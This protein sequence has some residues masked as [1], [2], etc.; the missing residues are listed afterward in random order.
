[1]LRLCGPANEYKHNMSDETMSA[2]A[3]LA[4]ATDHDAGVDIDSQPT[5]QTQNKNE[6]ASVEQDSSNERSASKEVDGGEQ[7]DVGTS[8]SS[9]TDSKAK[10]KEEKPKDQKSKFTQDQNR[11]TKTWE[12]INAEKEAIRADR[13]AVKR[14]REEWSKQREQST[15]ADTNSFRDEKG[16]TAEDY[17]AAAK[18]FDADGD[19][20]LAKAARAKADGVRKTVSVKQQQVQQE[21]FNKSWADNYSRLSEKEVWLK[22]QSSAE[23]KRTVELLHRIPIL[24]TLPNGLAHAVELMKLQNT[25]GRS[26]SLESENKALKE[27]LNKLQQKTA[28]GKSVPAGQLKTE[29]KDFSRLSQKEQRDALM[30]ATRE[31]DRESNQ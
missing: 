12:Q 2:D 24:T 28:I 22:D 18:E 23:Y 31:F 7:D 20:Q 15:V 1:L 21:R 16:Y 17:E 29:E 27:Q 11:K 25:A 8:K 6:S 3:M 10:Q 4:L 13:E 30:R 9:E 19:S 5:G 14:E 26:Q